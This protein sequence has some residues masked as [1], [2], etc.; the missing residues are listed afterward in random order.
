MIRLA[1]IDYNGWRDSALSLYRAIHHSGFAEVT[2]IAPSRWKDFGIDYD[3]KAARENPE[4]IP[5]DVHFNGK[6]HRVIFRGL[7]ATLRPLAPDVVLCNAEPENFLA[8]QLLNARRQCSRQFPVVL[9]SWRNIDYR[10]AGY[11]YKLGFLNA[12]IEKKVLPAIQGI[13]AHTSEASAAYRRYGFDHVVAIPPSIDL[14]RFTPGEAWRSARRSEITIGFIGRFIHLKGG[15]LLLHALQSLPEHVRAVFVGVGEENERWKE[16]AQSLGLGNRVTWRPPIRHEEMPEFYRTLDLLVLPSR[17]GKQWK[18][19]FGR[20]LIEAMACGVV[21]I[22]S[23][24]GEIPLVIHEAG[25]V[26]PENDPEALTAA[27]RAL[28]QDEDRRRRLKLLGHERVQS[29]FSI[30]AVVPRYRD[31]LERL[32]ATTR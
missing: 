31:L 6:Q 14:R 18:E 32:V 1:I 29:H 20:V 3:I 25:V 30:E 9:V 2:V 17:T 23:T 27:I 24:S 4:V 7:A 11:P 8:L 22:G 5:L 13:I 28:V 15:D 21:V 10:V 12:A 19:Q 16:L 26:F